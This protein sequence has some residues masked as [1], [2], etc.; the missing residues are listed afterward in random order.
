MEKVRTCIRCN[1]EELEHNMALKIKDKFGLCYPC[2][3]ELDWEEK[4]SNEELR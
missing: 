4:N 3:E 1:Q 2:D